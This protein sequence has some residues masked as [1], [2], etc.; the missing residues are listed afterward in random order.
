MSLGRCQEVYARKMRS[1]HT[2]RRISLYKVGFMGHGTIA[3]RGRQLSV[4]DNTQCGEVTG[5]SLSKEQFAMYYFS[6]A[7]TVLED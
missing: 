4:E 2:W 6:P 7:T 3:T 1:E 5:N